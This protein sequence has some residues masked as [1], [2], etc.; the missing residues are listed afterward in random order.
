MIYYNFIKMEFRI[1]KLN[2][3]FGMKII[4]KNNDLEIEKEQLLNAYDI[5]IVSR[6]DAINYYYIETIRIILSEQNYI[7]SP[8]GNNYE[9]IVFINNKFIKFSHGSF[10]KL[11]YNNNCYFWYNDETRYIFF[12]DRLPCIFF[13]SCFSE[14]IY[15]EDYYKLTK[16]DVL[17]MYYMEQKGKMIKAAKKT[18]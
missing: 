10:E 4:L 17:N 15:L 12:Q 8:E 18:G 6:N 1:L 2:I 7:Y 5:I 9:Y 13:T 14:I 3:I 11:Y 16:I